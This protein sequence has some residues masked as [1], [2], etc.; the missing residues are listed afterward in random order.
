MLEI[1]RKSYRN[2]GFYNTGYITIKKIDNYE[3]IYSKLL[4]LLVNNAN[5]YIEGKNRNKYLIF[6]T[7]DENKALL[8]KIKIYLEQN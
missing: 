7:T 5:R 1:D 3:R 8:K 6:D 4:Y 2:I